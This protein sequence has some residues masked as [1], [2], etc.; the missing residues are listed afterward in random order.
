MAILLTGFVLLTEARARRLR[1]DLDPA[2]GKTIQDFLAGFASG[3]GF[4]KAM[5]DRLAAVGEETLLTLLSAET[6]DDR[7]ARRRLRVT[8]RRQG[9]GAVLEFMAATGSENL[10]DRMTALGDRVDEV[11]AEQEVSLRLLR[12]LSSSVRHQQY[13]DADV[14]TVTVEPPAG[15]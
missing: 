7:P 1:T 3:S 9:A 2:A 10:Q 13:H 11:S 8:A 12:H 14:V 15:A 5:A 4:G 6:S